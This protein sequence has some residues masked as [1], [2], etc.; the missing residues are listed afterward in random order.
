MEARQKAGAERQ[1]GKERRGP[2]LYLVLALG[3]GLY[4]ALHMRWSALAPPIP[5]PDPSWACGPG[6]A[7]HPCPRRLQG[8]RGVGARRAVDLVRAGWAW[9]G[10]AGAF[11]PTT[12]SG[13][14]PVTNAVLEPLYRG[15]GTPA[16]A[17]AK[18]P[19]GQGGQRAVPAAPPI[20]AAS[21][22][23]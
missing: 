9:T 21:A 3:I 10:E 16:A 7:G 20:P 14:G 19:A 6:E 1:A 22:D 18:T 4:S 13:I 23:Q 2:P 15:P 12:V 17:P 5:E 8:L 11:D